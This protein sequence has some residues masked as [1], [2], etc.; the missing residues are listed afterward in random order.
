M[1]VEPIG[2]DEATCIAVDS[3]DS[4]FVTKDFVVTH[5][6]AGA[7]FE[8]TSHVTGLYPPWWKGRRFDTPNHWWV[9]GDTILTTR[10]ILQ[11]E[12]LGPVDGMNTQRWAGMIPAELVVGRPTRRSGSVADCAD[13]VRVRHVS[14]KTSTI[15]FM[16]YDQGRRAFQGT[17]RHGVWMDEEPPENEDIYGECLTRTLDV[18]GIVLMTFTPLRGFTKFLQDYCQTATFLERDGEQRPASEAFGVNVR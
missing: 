3:H 1:S 18:D 9:A 7:A 14:G 12:L 4:T 15:Q 11:V 6:T 8:V 16:S 5:N 2:A 10:N 17:S 13:T